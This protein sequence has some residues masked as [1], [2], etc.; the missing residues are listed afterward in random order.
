[1][2]K[3]SDEERINL[4]KL[5]NEMEYEDNTETIRRLKHSSKIRDNMR[6]MEEL[7]REHAQL[8]ITSPEQF[9]NIVQV[10]CNFLYDNYTD[11]FIFIISKPCK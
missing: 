9:F 7:K 8:R 5:M 1:M 2:S 6:K 3:L 10:E 4:K 11:I